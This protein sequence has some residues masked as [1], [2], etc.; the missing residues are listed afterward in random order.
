VTGPLG[1]QAAADLA[2]VTYRQVDH[3]CRA[4]YVRAPAD[5]SGTVRAIPAGEVEVLLM[6]ARMVN[7]G[8]NR[9]VA[10][11]LARLAATENLHTLPMGGGLVLLVGPR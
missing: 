6:M 1:T 9:T 11:R 7:A 8:L 3:W 10:A 4:G 2:G 5:G